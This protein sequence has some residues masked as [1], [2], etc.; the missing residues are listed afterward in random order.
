MS[1][2]MQA[3]K[4]RLK[5]T[6]MAGDYSHFAKFLE[7]GALDFLARLD[8]KPGVR[9]LDVACGA[10]QIVIPAARAGIDATGVDIATNLIAR[11]RERAIEEGLAARFDEGD[12]EGLPYEAA[13]FDVVT[14]LFGAMFAP[15]PEYVAAELLRVCR[16][17]GRIVMGNW[18]PQGHIGQMFKI[19]GKHVP[20]SPLMASPPAWG[21]EATARDRLH[22][23]AARISATKR[24]YPMRYPFAPADVVEFFITY[25][26]PTNRAHAALDAAGQAALRADL[27]QL[28]AGNNRATDGSTHVESEFLEIEVVRS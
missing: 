4:Q 7:P 18:T 13:S 9:M 23:G 26:G 3:L 12:A 27:E 22:A 2:E 20:P 17:S 14:S 15:R 16:P 21:D 8:L 6:W 19:I 25:Y 1:A 28:W 10:G 5:A 11:A 24:L